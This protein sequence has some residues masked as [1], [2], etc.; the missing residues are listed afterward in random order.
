VSPTWNVKRHTRLASVRDM[1]TGFGIA[2]LAC[3]PGIAGCNADARENTAGKSEEV[4]VDTAVRAP[5]VQDASVGTVG[6]EVEAEDVEVE[7][8]LATSTE[9]SV[10]IER[11]ARSRKLVWLKGDPAER[12][13]ASRDLHSSLPDVTLADVDQDGDLDLFWA[14]RFEEIIGAMVVSSGP[15]G[16]N[17][18]QMPA[19]S[20]RAPALKRNGEGYLVVLNTPAAFS[21]TQCKGMEAAR[22]ICSGDFATDWPRFFKLEHGAL[23]E[24]IAEPDVYEQLAAS[25]EHG[26]DHLDELINADTSEGMYAQ[27]CEGV[28][29]RL[30]E[31][32]DS[33]RALMDRG[34]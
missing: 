33:A 7:V 27:L 11:S 1:R 3:W 34:P 8:V 19:N 4:S 25:F 29:G 22:D 20:C 18:I 24:V 15:S 16:A 13:W 10:I 2:L 30:R 31:F 26:A 9:D 21:L 17:E 12:Y 6:S 5:S 32:A 28:P 14:L 23:E